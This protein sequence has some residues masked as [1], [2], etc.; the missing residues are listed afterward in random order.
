M[1]F[2]DRESLPQLEVSC[3]VKIR[4]KREAAAGPCP[5][6]PV[7]SH[8]NQQFGP[9]MATLVCDRNHRQKMEWGT[10]EITLMPLQLPRFSAFLWSICSGVL[11]SGVSLSPT[12][13]RGQVER[14]ESNRSRH[15]TVPGSK[16]LA[17]YIIG[18]AA[19]WRHPSRHDPTGL[20]GTI[21]KSGLH[22]WAS[23]L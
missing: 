18:L 12:G 8:Y 16:V 11:T 6:E 17:C 13:E 15:A 21:T 5:G 22:E 7:P 14:S 19:E 23:E 4:P 9:S 3:R 2:S 1:C 20:R 10:A